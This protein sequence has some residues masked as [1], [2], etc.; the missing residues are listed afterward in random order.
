MVESHITLAGS[1]PVTYAINIFFM[2]I[3]AWNIKQ[4]N[5]KSSGPSITA[6]IPSSFI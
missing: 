5:Q 3:K 6:K 4:E 1:N 2:I